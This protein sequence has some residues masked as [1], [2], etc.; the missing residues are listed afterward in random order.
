MKINATGPS[1]PSRDE[2]SVKVVSPREEEKESKARTRAKDTRRV[3]FSD[4]IAKAEARERKE[5]KAVA[6]R[7]RPMWPKKR[8]KK[9][10][11]RMM[12]C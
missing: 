9:R 11:W 12:R 7:L 1:T 6:Q 8:S 4:P 5:E 3:G 10:R 2:L